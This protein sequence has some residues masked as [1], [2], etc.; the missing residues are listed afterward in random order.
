MPIKFEKVPLGLTKNMA[1]ANGPA[2][3][4]K[5]ATSQGRLTFRR[6]CQQCISLYRVNNLIMKI[7]LI[8]TMTCVDQLK[9]VTTSNMK[10]QLCDILLYSKGQTKSK[11]FFQADVS[12]KKRTNE[13]NFTTMIP[14][15]D[16]F[17]FVFWKKLKTPKRHF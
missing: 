6:H 12:S 5:D 3:S 16:L 10:A 17:S 15:V 13:F 9:F 14:Q 8:I 11:L 1:D 7:K 4:K 2:Q